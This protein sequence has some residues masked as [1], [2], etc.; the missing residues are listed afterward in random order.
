LNLALSAA[1]SLS[2][3]WSFTIAGAGYSSTEGFATSGASD[4]FAVVLI[5]RLLASK[6]IKNAQGNQNED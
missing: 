4:I 1:Q 2:N 5:G 3:A 6:A